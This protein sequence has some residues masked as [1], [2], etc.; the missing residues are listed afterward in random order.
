MSCVRFET[1][2]S[3]CKSE[4]ACTHVVLFHNRAPVWGCRGFPPWES[5]GRSVNMTTH[6]PVELRSGMQELSLCSANSPPLRTREKFLQFYPSVQQNS[7]FTCASNRRT[8][9]FLKAAHMTSHVISSS[10]CGPCGGVLQLSLIPRTCSDRI[11]AGTTVILRCLTRFLGPSKGNTCVRP[12]R[13]PAPRC[14][15]TASVSE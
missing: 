4:A 10:L 14:L 15:D 12:Q 11:P 3:G 6:F 13:H 5:I 8:P 1:A 9:N 7:Y 2:S